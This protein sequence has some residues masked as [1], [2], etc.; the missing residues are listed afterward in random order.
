MQYFTHRNFNGEAHDLG[1]KTLIFPLPYTAL[2][3]VES[4]HCLLRTSETG[5]LSKSILSILRG[6]SDE[7][8][9]KV[10]K[11]ED[12]LLKYLLIFL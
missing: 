1:G 3:V 8:I 11:I 7:K 5:N 2:N 9:F 6:G 4:L 12:Q 10:M